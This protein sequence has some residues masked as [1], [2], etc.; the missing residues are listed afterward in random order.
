MEEMRSEYESVKLVP[1]VTVRELFVNSALR[2]PL[3]I[4]LMIMLAQQ[5][6]GINAVMFFSTEIFK[7]AKLDQA[8]SQNATMGVG[9][10][11]VFMTLVSL[12]LVERAGRKQLLLIG[13][14]GMIFVTSLLAV[15]L[16]NAVSDLK[17]K[18]LHWEI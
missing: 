3:F 17:K 10:M 13:F 15:C 2:I 18:L 5:F 6:S 11:N 14:G 12:I 1:R 8:A 4:A 9:A 16:L 7:M